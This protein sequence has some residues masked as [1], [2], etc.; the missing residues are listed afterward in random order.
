MHDWVRSYG[1][2][3]SHLPCR[4]PGNVA[5]MAMFHQR[6]QTCPPAMEKEQELEKEL[7]QEQELGLEQ[8]LWLKLLLPTRPV[9]SLKTRILYSVKSRVKG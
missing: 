4:Q 5:T 7:E 8:E 6:Q 1:F 9:K 2:R 3:Y